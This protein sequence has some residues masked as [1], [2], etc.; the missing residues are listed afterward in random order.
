MLYLNRLMVGHHSL[1]C[2]YRFYI[3]GK[4]LSNKYT[5]WMT[6]AFGPSNI[7]YKLACHY[8]KRG[9][10]FGEKWVLKEEWTSFGGPY[11]GEIFFVKECEPLVFL[12]FGGDQNETW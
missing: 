2:R 7:S 8:A 12:S 4:S 11:V 6:N 9:M 1:F 3:V 10:S 5:T